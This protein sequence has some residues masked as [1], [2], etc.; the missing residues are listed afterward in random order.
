[1]EAGLTPAEALQTATLNP[2]KFFNKFSSLGTIEVGKLADLV[3]LDANPLENIGNTQRINAVVVNGE[4]FTK[5]ALQKMLSDVE[6]A[7]QK[8]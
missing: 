4:Y 5:E 2:A 6:A 1:V 3:L 8:Q 7:A